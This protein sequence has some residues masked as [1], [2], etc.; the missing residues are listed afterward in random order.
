MTKEQNLEEKKKQQ[1]SSLLSDQELK[2]IS[3]FKSKDDY[4]KLKDQIGI[5]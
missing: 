4:Y 3:I 1:L 5:K 2:S